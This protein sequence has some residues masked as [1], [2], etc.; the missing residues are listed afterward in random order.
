MS[1]TEYDITQVI[2]YGEFYSAVMSAFSFVYSG[3]Y[4]TFSGTKEE[5]LVEMVNSFKKEVYS[6]GVAVA[7]D[8]KA[9]SRRKKLTDLTV[10]IVDKW[11]GYVDE[12]KGKEV[13]EALIKSTQ[14]LEVKLSNVFTVPT[15]ATTT[16]TAKLA[17]ANVTSKLGF[18]SKKVAK[19][20]SQIVEAENASAK[21][22]DQKFSAT[23]LH[24]LDV[25]DEDDGGR[26]DSG[27]SGGE[28]D[29]EDED[30]KK[31][32]EEKEGTI[33]DESDKRKKRR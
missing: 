12:M 15:T 23:Y 2:R 20:Y 29:K 26:S 21:K 33:K 3:M 27:D 22:E 28:S 11:N 5:G 4:L 16:I 6:D 1:Q 8:D 32:D 31:E 30:K 17:Y 13:A 19:K 25:D 18:L 24:K 7:T 10:S 9:Q 14:L